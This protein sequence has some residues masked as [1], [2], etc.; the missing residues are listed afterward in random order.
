M[1]LLTTFAPKDVKGSLSRN[2]ENMLNITFYAY[3]VLETNDI[4]NN[5]LWL[6][7]I[8]YRIPLITS[9]C[10]VD[11]TQ[12]NENLRIPKAMNRIM[13]SDKTKNS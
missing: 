6:T 1:V 4:K 13:L 3:Q 12:L 7:H 8:V 2:P 10:L 11:E 9:L 5:K